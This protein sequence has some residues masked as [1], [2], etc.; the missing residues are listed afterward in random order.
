MVLSSYRFLYCG[1]E[2]GFASKY[3]GFHIRRY[4]KS[5]DG[6]KEDGSNYQLAAYYISLKMGLSI[7]SEVAKKYWDI[8]YGEYRKL[9]RDRL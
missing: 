7:F 4:K 3:K 2:R 6:D 9:V 1:K 8:D 5:L